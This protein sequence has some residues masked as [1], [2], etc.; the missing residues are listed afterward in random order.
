MRYPAEPARYGNPESLG[1]IVS[2]VFEVKKEISGRLLEV[3]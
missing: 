1:H 3:L 2:S